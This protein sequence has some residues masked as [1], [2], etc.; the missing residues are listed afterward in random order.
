MRCVCGKENSADNLD[1]EKAHMRINANVEIKA[2]RDE[3][4]VI[5]CGLLHRQQSG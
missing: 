3:C 2:A 4:N 1:A 5:E